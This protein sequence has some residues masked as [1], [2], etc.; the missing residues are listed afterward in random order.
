MIIPNKDKILKIGKVHGAYIVTTIIYNA[1]PLLFLPI[2]TRYLPPKEYA[3][4]ALFNFYFAIACSLAGTSVPAMISKNFFDQPKDYVAK[5]VGNSISIVFVFSLIISVVILIFNKAIY[6]V[7]DLSLF[8]MLVVT[9]SAF[10]FIVFNIGLTV[11]RNQSKVLSYSYHRI[12]NIAMNICISFIFVVFLLWGWQGRIWGTV[13]SLVVS[14]FF[15]IRYLNSQGY[16]SFIYSKEI[17]NKTLN[18]LMYL[19]PNS[20]QSVIIGQVG[21]FFMQ[22]YYTKDLL[23]VYSVGFQV[24]YSIKILFMAL[25]L[26]WAPY[27]YKKL[28]TPESINRVSLARGFYA[29][30]GIMVLGIIFVNIFSGLIL[31]VFTTPGYFGAKEF[32]FW[33]TV[34]FFF[35]AMYIFMTPILIKKEKQKQIN[36]VSLINMIIMIVLNIIFVDIFG[37]IGIPYAFCLTYFIMFLSLWFLVQ[38]ELPLPWLKALKIS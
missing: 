21:I 9:W 24:A 28:S 34:G 20:L 5:I 30:G 25:S 13:I 8:W 15:S 29:L 7:T 26:S 11:M 36:L 38:K 37:Y 1:L 18:L 19:I 23:G 14:A 12:G 6:S 16:L 10:L 32:I 31:R 33:F 17:I 4:I 27:L 35:H 2:L 3:N 22:L